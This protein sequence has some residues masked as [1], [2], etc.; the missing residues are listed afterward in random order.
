MKLGIQTERFDQA[1]FDFCV[2]ANIGVFKAIAP[3]S[4]ALLGQLRLALPECKFIYRPHFETQPLDD[5]ERRAREAVDAVMGH[6]EQFPYDYTELYNQTGLWKKA[7]DYIAFTIEAARLLE[8]RGQKLLAYSFSWGNPCGFVQD[9]YEDDPA[10]WLD[11]LREHWAPYCDGLRAV[12]AAGGG[13][14]L[15]QYKVPDEDDKFSIFRHRLVREVLPDDLKDILIDLTEFGLDHRADPGASGWSGDSWGWTPAQYA[16]WLIKTA[17]AIGKEVARAAIFICGTDMWTSFDIL[18]HPEIADAIAEANRPTD[19]TVLPDW[20][21]DL[22]G[23]AT[24]PTGLERTGNQGIVVHHSGNDAPE[25][26]QISYLLREPD[27]YH[28]AI[29]NDGGI[30][31]LYD[32]KWVVWHTSHEAW[33]HGGVAAAFLGLFM[34]GA[35]PSEAAFAAFRKLHRWLCHVEGVA[36][37]VAGHKDFA[38]TDCPGDSYPGYRPRLFAATDLE[39]VAQRVTKLERTLSDLAAG[40]KALGDDLENKLRR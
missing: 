28:F 12:Q 13:L 23:Q 8:A 21:E 26:N 10:R 30:V 5:P 38:P 37:V 40:F 29:R 4:V 18:G 9:P 39:V 24:N 25:A 6:L 2:R 22:R 34:G 19:G 15:H 14:A 20:I 1:V 7:Y 17:R 32:P 36:D 16:A 33:N 11:G 3:Q 27:T 31:C 35:M